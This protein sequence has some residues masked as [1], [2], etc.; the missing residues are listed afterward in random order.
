MGEMND[1]GALQELAT[2]NANV[3]HLFTQ[4]LDE[5]VGP[6]RTSLKDVEERLGAETKQHIE[7]LEGQIR[8][9]EA[10]MKALKTIINRPGTVGGFDDH[11]E[12]ANAK[13][14]SA[15]FLKA[16]KYNWGALSAEEKKHVPHDNVFG[17][18][19]GEKVGHGQ[20]AEHKTMFGSDAT[21]GGFLA[22]PEVAD[23]LIKLV[24]QISD[25]YS[26]VTVR[27][28][29][30]PWVMIRKR[31]QTGSAS[32]TP[33]QATRTETQTPKF[34]MV[35]VTPYTA[36][37]LTKIST[38][39]LDD[40]ELDLPAFIMAEFAEQFAKLVGYE[41]ANGTGSGANQCQGFLQDADITGTAYSGSG[42]ATGYTTSAA[43]GGFGYADLIDLVH[44]TKPAYR[45]GA[46]WA[47]TT[48]TLGDMRKLTDSMNRPLWGPM[49]GDLPGQLL[50]YPYE[51][52]IDMPSVASGNFPIAFANWQKW[53]TIVVR[54]Q[55]SVRVLQ[56]RYADED[57]M[58]YMGYYRFGGNVTLSEA[59]HV[60]KIA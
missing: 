26:L 29:A 6:I 55:V 11:E 42:G 10:E 53:Y 7:R 9:N 2:K 15:A 30:N 39:D 24:V 16:L 37:A 8:T 36:Y 40:S 13:A 41:I 56:E 23:E 50:Q 1:M 51:E 35:Q 58:G 18:A 17:L 45:K 3:A 28:T 21:T 60:L 33:E 20:S 52:M 22:T 5:E 4:V 59:G 57:A 38:Q 49:G 44:A 25:F 14:R 54:K 48:E 34:G 12:K 27:M 43:V 46:S 19:Q 32:R 47:F 31:I